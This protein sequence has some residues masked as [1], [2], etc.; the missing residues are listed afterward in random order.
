MTN[1]YKRTHWI[2]GRIYGIL[3]RLKNTFHVHHLTSRKF[4]H[5]VAWAVGVSVAIVIGVA[6]LG[7]AAHN[8]QAALINKPDV[9]IYL[10][11]PDEKLGK[12]TLIKANKED[13]VRDYL[14]E[15][16][17]GPMLVELKKT[18]KWYVALTEQLHEGA[19]LPEGSTAETPPRH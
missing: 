18:D 5:T 19:A 14:A 9:A 13:T 16:P 12:T 8:F 6:G 4:S 10:L 15:T 2:E 11:L 7:R 17:H 3:E 1:Q